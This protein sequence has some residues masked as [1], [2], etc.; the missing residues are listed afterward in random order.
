MEEERDFYDMIDYLLE[1][2]KSLNSI[3]DTDTLLFNIITKKQQ[4]LFELKEM[5]ETISAIEN[6]LNLQI[7]I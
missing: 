3:L 6:E 2:S 7:N 1:C 4:I 5:K